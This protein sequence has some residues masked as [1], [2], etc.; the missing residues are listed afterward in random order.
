MVASI[1]AG[2]CATY[3]DLGQAQ[4]NP[5]SGKIVGRWMASAPEGVPW[6]RVIAKTGDLPISKRDPALG[7]TQRQLLEAD[8]VPFL[9]DGRV[10][11]EAC[12]WEP[13]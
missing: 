11:L 12:R 1:P 9:D 5:V 3:G 6:W 4:P 2:C 8:G 13:R 7:M 10:D